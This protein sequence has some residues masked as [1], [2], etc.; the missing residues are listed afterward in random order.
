MNVSLKEMDKGYKLVEKMKKK[1]NS[2]NEEITN[3]L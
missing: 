1:H 2:K 3:I